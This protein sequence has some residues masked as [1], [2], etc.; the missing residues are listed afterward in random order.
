MGK[1]HPSPPAQANHAAPVAAVL[2]GV[3]GVGRMARPFSGPQ[4][5]ALRAGGGQGSWQP[6]S[7][8][9]LRAV[10]DP[11]LLQPLE[12]RRTPLGQECADGAGCRRGQLVAPLARGPELPKAGVGLAVRPGSWG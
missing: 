9:S 3:M 7:M 2:M 8:I 4:G 10:A 6:Q 12:G 5:Q 11:R 1:V